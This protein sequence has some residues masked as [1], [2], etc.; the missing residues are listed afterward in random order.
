MPDDAAAFD[1]EPGK[2]YNV[3]PD[4][5]LLNYKTVG[6]RFL[7]DA[8][9]TAVVIVLSKWDLVRDFGGYCRRE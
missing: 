7:P 4:A 5:L 2:P 1:G 9:G 8:A 3:G 6:V